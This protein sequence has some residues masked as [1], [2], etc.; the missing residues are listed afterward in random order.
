MFQLTPVRTAKAYNINDGSCW[1]R[2]TLLHC[3]LEYQLSE[4][5]NFSVYYNGNFGP[6]RRVAP[7][8]KESTNEVGD[9]AP[10]I[11]LIVLSFWACIRGREEHAG[12][13]RSCHGLTKPQK[14]DPVG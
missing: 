6:P 5:L 12:G 7:E 13:K 4:V 9:P 3:L 10:K 2:I 8:M 14:C 11:F 1:L